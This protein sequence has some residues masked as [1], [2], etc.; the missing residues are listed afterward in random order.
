[1]ISHSSFGTSTQFIHT[2]YETLRPQIA[3]CHQVSP[4]LEIFVFRHFR[5]ARAEQE[6]PL[7]HRVC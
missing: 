2:E 5:L 6:Q 4:L 7:S 1:M 3:D